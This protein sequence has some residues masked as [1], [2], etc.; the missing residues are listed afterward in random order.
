MK[1]LIISVFFCAI[2]AFYF[3]V[4]TFKNKYK[5]FYFFYT[6]LAGALKN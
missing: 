3:T 1:Q 4:V 5:T 2:T 6:V